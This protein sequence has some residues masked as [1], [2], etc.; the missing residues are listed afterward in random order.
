MVITSVQYHYYWLSFIIIVPCIIVNADNK[1][2]STSSQPNIVTCPVCYAT[3]A[4][5]RFAPHLEK[6]L[7]G[8]TRGGLPAKKASLSSSSNNM[9]IGLP[10]YTQVKKVDP[11][12][13]SLIVRVRL[14]DG[15]NFFFEVSYFLFAPLFQG[16]FFSFP[17]FSFVTLHPTVLIF[18]L[19]KFWFSWF[20]QH[21][22]L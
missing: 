16:F 10:Y 5:T 14:K 6:C 8:G 11:Y 13:N 1:K 15:G 18:L 7:N 17:S 20:S 22:L 21:F 9:G 4:G 3:V 2:T 19:F 12:P